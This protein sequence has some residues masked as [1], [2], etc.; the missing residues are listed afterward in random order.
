MSNLCKNA[1]SFLQ[2]R[3]PVAPVLNNECKF[4]DKN[5]NII[6][7][8]WYMLAQ[9]A[10][11]GVKQRAIAI[12]NLGSKDELL[13]I[14][15][16]MQKMFDQLDS[17]V[18]LK[19]GNSINRRGHDID[20]NQMTFAPRLILYTNKL[21]VPIQYIIDAFN[22]VNVLVD[23]V[24]ESEMHKSL[25][26]SYGGPD[27]NIVTEINRLI[28]SKGVKT[29]FFPEDALPGDKLHRIM[30]DGVNNHDRVLLVC[31]EQSLSRPG[32]LNE[33]ERVLER[34]AKEG[35]KEILIP[36]T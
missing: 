15:G 30:H 11:S 21:C 28:K 14:A 25:F 10:Q 17:A 8:A 19:M 35:G 6:L 7:K 32:V 20:T 26:I 33:I 3:F 34:E 23:V 24:D 31:S 18:Y 12:E 4:P 1:I 22:S 27:E 36:I 29:W 16:S 5:G 9:D 13:S 2:R